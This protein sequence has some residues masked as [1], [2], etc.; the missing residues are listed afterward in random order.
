MTWSARCSKDGGI[1]N[2]VRQG[3]AASSAS[4][5]SSGQWGGTMARLLQ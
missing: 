3:T 2:P 5:C 1:V 4:P